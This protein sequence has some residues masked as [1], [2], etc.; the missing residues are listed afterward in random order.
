MKAVHP[1]P[2]LDLRRSLELSKSSERWVA[3]FTQSMMKRP[4]QFAPG[5]FPVYLERGQGATVRDVDGNEYIDLVCGLGANSLGHNHWAVVAAISSNLER[6]LIHSLP[7]PVEIRAA[8]TLCGIVPGAEMVRF[9]KTGA[10]ANSAAIR[11][12]RHATRRDHIITVGYNGWHDQFM[13]DTPG[14]PEGVAQYTTRQNLMS[15]ADDDKLLEQVRSRGSELAAVLLSLP[16]H[17]CVDRTFMHALRAACDETGALLVFDEIVTGF[18][19][20]LGGASEY[21]G[22]QPD[23][24]TFSKSLAAGMP[25]SA[26][27]G[28]RGLMAKIE[29]L[30]VST[31]FGGEILS[32]EVCAAALAEY[33][34]SDYIARLAGLGRQLAEGVNAR[35]AKVGSG[36]RVRG[37]A[38]IPMFLFSPDRAEHLRSAER[39]VGEMAARGVLMRRDVNFICGAHTPEHIDHVIEACASALEAMRS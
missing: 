39:F 3:G 23:L 18:R 1:S 38:A 6:G 5:K 37:Y 13:F 25:L 19:L 9:F 14:V 8:Q 31:T 12:A 2:S 33:R 15:P 28:P 20:A 34:D 26:V 30:Q 29:D 11:L 21:F 7:D 4:D 35:A 16:Y 24:A 22:V 27:T 36:L 10:D 17:R 32:L